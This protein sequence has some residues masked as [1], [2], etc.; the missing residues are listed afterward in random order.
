MNK[1]KTIGV[2]GGM[3]P[4]A[5]A[6]FY[7][8][9]LIL[10]Q[11]KYGSVQDEEYPHIIL[12]SLALRGSNE[13]GMEKKGVIKNQLIDG[14]KALEKANV[15]FIVIPCNSVHNVIN[16][17]RK[18]S[19]VPIISIIEKVVDQVKVCKSKKTLILSSETTDK[20]GLYDHLSEE[21]IETVKPDTKLKREMTKLICSVMGGYSGTIFKTKILKQINL[22][23]K[24]GQI[25][26]VVLGCTELPVTIQ[27]K[28]TKVKLYDSL[29]ILA[30]SALEY[31]Q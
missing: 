4:C 15:D 28:D 9:L 8:L 18:V 24:K 19:R 20:Y 10:S 17:L 14:I 22:M 30:E 16:E 25:D 11:Q 7:Q 12:N 6:Y 3:G 1:F 21:R 29:K 13:F 2:L 5:S 31:A 27:A 23:Y 26:S